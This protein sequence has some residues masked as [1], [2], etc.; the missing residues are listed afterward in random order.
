[1]PIDPINASPIPAQWQLG[2]RAQRGERDNPLTVKPD[3]PHCVVTPVA[4]GYTI[5]VGRPNF[6]DLPDLS[7]MYVARSY[8]ELC[9]VLKH[10]AV[11]EKLS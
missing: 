5:Q 8:A 10:I 1:M 6:G 11:R 2:K 9:R 3:L 4:N 7:K